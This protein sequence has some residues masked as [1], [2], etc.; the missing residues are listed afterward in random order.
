MLFIYLNR[1]PTAAGKY[2]QS[3]ASSRSHPQTTEVQIGPEST[4]WPRE[5]KYLGRILTADGIRIG[6]DRV[7]ATVDVPTP[8]TIKELR[9]VLG[10]VNFA[11]KFIPNLAGTIAPLVALSKK[12]PPKKS[13]NVGDQNTIRRT[14]Q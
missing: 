6:E 1:P 10:M 14:Q 11:R 12:R 3:L 9:S 13:L 2:V 5:V 8:K 7:K 4:V